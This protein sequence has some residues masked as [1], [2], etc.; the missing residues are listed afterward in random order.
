MTR[1]APE[2]VRLPRSAKGKRPHFFAD[3]AIDQVMTFVLELMAETTALRERA[4]TVERL[5]EANGAV[6][7]ADIEAYRPDPE[8]E[9]QRAAWADEFVRRVLRLHDPG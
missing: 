8:L 1:V 6:S 9:Q 7:R 2:D 5:L 3:P 4:D